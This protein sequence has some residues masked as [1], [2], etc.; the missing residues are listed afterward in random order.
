M[1]INAIL[2][3]RITDSRPDIIHDHGIWLP[4]NHAVATVARKHKVPLVVHPRGMLEPWA[5]S[6]RSYKK[7][8][9]WNLYQGRNLKSAALFFAT[10][11]A[12]A[13]NLRKL[14]F[15]QPI[16]VIPNGV[17]IPDGDAS[18]RSVQL[19]QRERTVV[20]MSRVHPKKGLKGL[21]KAWAKLDPE[22]W[23]L[24]LAGPD[25]GGHL[26][27]ILAYAK[28]LRIDNKVVYQGVVEGEDKEKL[29]LNADLFVLPSFSENFGVVV[30]EALAY[31]VPVI[32]TFGTPWQGLVHNKC[33]WWVEAESG[34][35]GGALREA[36]ALS[37]EQRCEM[38][39]RGREYARQFDW[40]QIARETADVYH[41]LLGKAD[42]PSCVRLN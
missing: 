9:A 25:E 15:T 36:I 20:F 34:A 17:D 33:G 1:V 19:A 37:D 28:K 4:S 2:E 40:G 16:A 29:L 3:R 5:L 22:N 30:A 18:F 8:L 14:D 27:E 10:S 31:G 39:V 26:Q 41:W 7:K 42:C 12:E 23:K 11:Q 13:D 35:L 6:F 24:I 32:S 21:L 38:G